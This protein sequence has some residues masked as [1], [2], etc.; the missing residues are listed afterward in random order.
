[1]AQGFA[2]VAGGSCGRRGRTAGGSA[3]RAGKGAVRRHSVDFA[4]GIRATLRGGPPDRGG[5]ASQGKLIHIIAETRGQLREPCRRNER[6]GKGTMGRRHR[7]YV[8]AATGT[9]CLAPSK[10]IEDSKSLP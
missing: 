6:P 5:G 4:G 7:A 8:R 10:K 1:A 2:A 9:A 3:P